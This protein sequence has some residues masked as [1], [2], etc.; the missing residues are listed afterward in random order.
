VT[1]KKNKHERGKQTINKAIVEIIGIEKE[2]YE[3]GKGK[4]C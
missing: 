1:Q 3:E 4:K 2:K